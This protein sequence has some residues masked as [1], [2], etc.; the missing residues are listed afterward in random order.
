MRLV[1]AL[2][3]NLV[4]GRV[5]SEML[6][7]PYCKW[8]EVEEGEKNPCVT[9]AAEKASA[10]QHGQKRRVRVSAVLARKEFVREKSEHRGNRSKINVFHQQRMAGVCA[11][12]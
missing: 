9:L 6:T 7:T 3:G 1:P 5:T 12:V 11:C 8:C 4:A 10:P 2:R